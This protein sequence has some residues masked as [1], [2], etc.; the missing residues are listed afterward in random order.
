MPKTPVAIIPTA[1]RKT[2]AAQ[3]C[4][5]S[6]RSF[7]RLVASKKVLPRRSGGGRVIVYIRA[8]LDE[9]MASEPCGKGDRPGAAE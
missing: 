5:M 9:M 6:L 1:M 7:E 4:G 3:Y 8:E 2:D